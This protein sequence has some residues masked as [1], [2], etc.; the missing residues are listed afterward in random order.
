M[1]L[2]EQV[3]GT[4]NLHSVFPPKPPAMLSHILMVKSGKRLAVYDSASN[5]V[6]PSDTLLWVRD[7][8][9][10]GDIYVLNCPCVSGILIELQGDG[11]TATVIFNDGR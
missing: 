10:A 3:S 8:P 5:V 6:S 7:S 2:R 11:A 4:R 1:L 9:Q